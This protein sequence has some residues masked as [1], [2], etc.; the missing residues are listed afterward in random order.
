MAIGPKNAISQIIPNQLMPH[1]PLGR[2]AAAIGG[3]KAVS[4]L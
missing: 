4:K 2:Q 3:P 1:T